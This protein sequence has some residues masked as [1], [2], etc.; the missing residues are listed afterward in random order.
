MGLKERRWEPMGAA[1]EGDNLLLVPDP[2]K[3]AAAQGRLGGGD[4]HSAPPRGDLW[5][6]DVGGINR[7]IV[8]TSEPKECSLI[9]LL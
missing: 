3:R 7:K 2:G 8:S 4:F 5:G 1:E 9:H 6:A